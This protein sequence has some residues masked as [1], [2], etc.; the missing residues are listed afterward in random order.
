M[1]S[2]RR[3][4][5]RDFSQEI[6]AHI[7]LDTDRL[8]AEGMSP[9]EAKA[10]ALR[11][12][13]NVTS[14]QERFYES[15]RVM[16]LDDFQRDVRYALRALTRTPG[17]TAVAI[18]ILALGI[19]TN[20]AIFSLIDTLMLRSLPV[21]DPEQLV[22]LLSNYPGEPRSLGFAWRYY[23]HYRDQ[24]H[25]FSDLIGVSATRFQVNNRGLDAD[26]V[27]G[28]FV[29][30]NFFRA[31]GVK[32]AIGRLLGAQD[33]QVGA[34]GAAVAVVSWSY[35]KDTFNL[36]SA[37]LGTKIILDG[38]P[39]IVVGVVAREFVGLQVGLKSDVWV[40]AAMEPMIRR[41]SQR[42]DG[43]LGLALMGRLKPGVSI[44]QARAEM[45]VLDRWRI[46]DVLTR[47]NDPLWRQA[48]I[49]V[50]P[51][52]AGF[53]T[54]RDQ[55]VKPLIVL[56][57]L[58]CLLLLLACTNIASM[59][60]ARG[61]ARQRE[62][63]V[64]VALGATRVRLVRQALTESL[65]L[66]VAGSLVGILLAYVGVETLIR[67]IAS[68]RPLVG[69]PGPI[70][71][72]I[73]PDTQMLLFTAGVALLTAALFGLAPAW[74]AFVS[75]PSS[76]LRQSGATAETR[77]TRLF[78][79]ALVVAQVALSVVLLSTAGLFVR[80]LSNL[81]NV[82]LGFRRE[83]VLLVTLNP[84]GSGYNRYQLTRMFRDLIDR[85]QA[86]PGVRSV[87]LSGVTPIEGGAASRF[88]NVEGLQERP[89]DRR[90]LMLNWVGP[91]YFET[92]G[93]PL[94]AGRD[95]E[96][97]D[98]SRTRVAIVN[99]M[100]ARHYFP[101]SDPIGKHITLDGDDQPYEIVGVAGDAKYTNLYDAPPRTVY[102]NAFQEERIGSQFAL[103]TN[104]APETIASEAR[105]VV[106][107]VVNNVR[108]AK[109]T[110]LADQVDAAIVPE[111]LIAPLASFFGVVGAL[112]AAIGLYGLLAYMVARRIKEIGIRRA[113]GATKRDITKMVLKSALVVVGPGLLVGALVA[114][115][116][117]RFA[118]SVMENLPMESV[119]PLAFAAVAMIAVAL[120]AAY[121][122]ARRA[123][124][125]DPMVALR[126]E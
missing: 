114:I 107:D 74:T 39:A 60:L 69:W 66:S 78:G 54:L 19:G 7:L 1:W 95:F 25:V 82:D 71:I 120:L 64:R 90:R 9:Q 24:N 35:W 118:A 33:D 108:V 49:D 10:A 51:A 85:L 109:V 79:K 68:G 26:R 52:G 42:A 116:S 34:A 75:I 4:S 50:E 98:E 97:Q 123:T 87:S 125:V 16:W 99:Q 56:M 36:D 48:K 65:L 101:G 44:D 126:S 15:R 40:P 17:F 2:W 122:P 45:S 76:S 6:Q 61:A 63:A 20:T 11:T 73:R 111:R 8:I 80:H 106:G 86:I 110:T 104:E 96:F 43:S 47:S 105:R 3:R 88:A 29:P 112:L 41:P 117:K 81:R 70:D 5:S 27:G 12:F 59:L 18:L 21:R 30:G 119:F 103:R 124:R 46:E 57:I 37:I 67:I 102:F 14:A 100:T 77:S 72:Q 58:V 13:G 62:I 83:S 32:P 94:L 121:V 31:L 28:E 115:W 53:S 89:E 38:V 84:Q 23:E 55:Y 92:F 91:K 113:L 22:Q 93:T